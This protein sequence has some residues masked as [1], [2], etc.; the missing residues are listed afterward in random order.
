MAILKFNSVDE[1]LEEL[2]KSQPC[3]TIVRVTF[4]F[5]PSSLSPNIRHLSVV[6]TFLLRGWVGA[7]QRPVEDIVRLDKFCGDTWGLNGEED[8]KVQDRAEAIFKLIEDVCKKL[9][10]EVRAGVLEEAG[11]GQS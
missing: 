4:L 7:E 1:F 2:K 9:G 8:K 3:P 10:Y 11:R 5:T 6:S